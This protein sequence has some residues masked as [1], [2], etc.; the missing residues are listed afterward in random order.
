MSRWYAFTPGDLDF[1]VPVTVAIREVAVALVAGC[2]FGY[3]VG[4]TS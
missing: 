3:F 4:V 1:D 2:A